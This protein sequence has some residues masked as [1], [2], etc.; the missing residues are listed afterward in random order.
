MFLRVSLS[1]ESELQLLDAAIGKVGE[2]GGG[3]GGGEGGGGEGGGGEGG[4][5]EGGGGGGVGCVAIG[6]VTTGIESEA[7]Q[8]GNTDATVSIRVSIHV[9]SIGYI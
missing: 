8:E 1:S 3:G 2:G 4:G 5:G 6:S 9:Y 7:M